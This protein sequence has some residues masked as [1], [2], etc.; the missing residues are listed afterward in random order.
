MALTTVK[1]VVLAPMP[2]AR[3][4]MAMALKPGF[5]MRMR[6]GV[7]YVLQ[8][9]VHCSHLLAAPSGDGYCE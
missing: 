8:K 4:R 6:E 1:M 9:I 5:L 3:E 2:R 7:P